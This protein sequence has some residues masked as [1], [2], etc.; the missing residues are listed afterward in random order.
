MLGKSASPGGERRTQA[1]APVRWRIE[2]ERGAIA[3]F[4]DTV[5]ALLQAQVPE[6]ALR[7]LQIAIDELLTNV[8]MHA[9]QAA[10]PIEVEIAR[11]PDALATTISYIADQFDPTA[12]QPLP[13]ELSIA[14][15]RVGGLGIQLVRSLMDGFAYRYDAGF[16]IVTL[17]KR[18]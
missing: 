13:Q 8:V 11:E 18:C 17:R 7:A 14:G 16:N 3:R 2:R 5:E 1:S 15:T 6:A 12:W 4:N 9:A 10:G